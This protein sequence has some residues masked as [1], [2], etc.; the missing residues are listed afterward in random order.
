MQTQNAV[1]DDLP[2]LDIRTVVVMW[3]EGEPRPR[4]HFTNCS[5]FEA[6]GLARAAT[7][8]LEDVCAGSID[9]EGYDEEQD[10]DDFI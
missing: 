1:A 4:V 8:C 7:L 6:L 10:D 2:D 9:L 5:E 3:G